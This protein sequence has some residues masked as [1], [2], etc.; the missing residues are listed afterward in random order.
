MIKR[1]VGSDQG[2]PVARTSTAAGIPICASC[3]ASTW[4]LAKDTLGGA[5]EHSERQDR[6]TTDAGEIRRTRTG[7]PMASIVEVLREIAE[8]GRHHDGE[9][10]ES[11]ENALDSRDEQQ[12]TRHLEEGQV[13]RIRGVCT[14]VRE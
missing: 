9:S 7:A 11:R 4:V 6:Q 10:R 14:I 13:T 1:L 3:V 5:R 2:D 12:A 8:E